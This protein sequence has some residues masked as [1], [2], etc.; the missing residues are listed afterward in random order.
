MTKALQALKELLVC[1][2]QI[3]LGIRSKA[4]RLDAPLR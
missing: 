4:L 1:P 3:D 2:H